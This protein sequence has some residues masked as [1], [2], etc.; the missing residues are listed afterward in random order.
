M[1]SEG[2][3]KMK[4][5]TMLRI[6]IILLILIMIWSVLDS[7]GI[8]NLIKESIMSELSFEDTIGTKIDILFE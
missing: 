6:V 5:L 2:E 3:I 8:L 7:L 4:V 1:Q